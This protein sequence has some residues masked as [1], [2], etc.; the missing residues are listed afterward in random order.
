MNHPLKKS[1][2]LLGLCLSSISLSA[3]GRGNS[4]NDTYTSDG[5]LKISMRNLYFE[6]WSGDDIYTD[7]LEDKFQV[8]ID[9]STYSYNDWTNQV[10]SAVNAN[11][12]TDVFQF[13]VTQFNFANSY[14][15]WAEGDIIK[16]LPDDLSKWPNVEKMIN[17]VTDISALKIDGHLY[18]LP[19]A[20]NISKPNVDYSPFTYIYRR[21]WAKSWGVYKDNDEYTWSEFLNLIDVFNQ[22]LNPTGNSSTY[23]MADVEWG[24]P[25]LTNFY[26]DVPH[27]FSFDKTNKKYVSNF[28]TDAYVQGMDLAKGYVDTKVYGYDQYSSTEGGARKAYDTNKCGILYENLS[29]SNYQ[30]IRTALG[31][32]NSLDKT[33]DVDNASA[34]MKVRGPDGKYALEGTDN[35]F[36]MTLFNSSISDTKMEKILDL[37]DYLL[38]DEGTELAVYGKEGYDYTKDADGTIQLTENGWPVGDDGKYVA[39]TN[40][41]KYL[42]YV[43]TLGSDYAA[44]D[45]LTNMDTYNA[46]NSWSETMDAANTS[47]DLRVLKENSEVMW[48]S[49]TAK[50]KYESSLLENATDEVIRYCYGKDDKAT[51][52]ASVTG[53]QWSNV[54]NEVNVALGYTK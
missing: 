52:L 3:C 38:G 27:C 25:S 48:L 39:K 31:T 2:L 32:T 12:L 4:G 47:G 43:A 51:Y 17:N 1:L 29:Q 42:R 20:K 26:K 34:I 37:L 9:P 30:A 22:H 23:V 54:L 10:S 16:A 44:K 7:L 5:K 14:K 19:I 50:D 18:G 45:P 49:T 35:W 53:G 46:L 6:S 40:G 21:D 33:F 13:N 8:S 36:S 28:G 41:A 15:Y 24:F 11:N